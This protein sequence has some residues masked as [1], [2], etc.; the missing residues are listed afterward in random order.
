[1]CWGREGEERLGSS[2]SEFVNIDAAIIILVNAVKNLKK[3]EVSAEQDGERTS[4]GERES[5]RARERESEREG[6]REKRESE[7]V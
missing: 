6:E 5:A 2:S 1:V 3:L 7:R 4:Q